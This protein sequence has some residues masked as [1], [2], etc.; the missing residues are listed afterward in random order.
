M[1][2]TMDGFAVYEFR[3]VETGTFLYRTTALE[4]EIVVANENLRQRESTFRFFPVGDFRIPSLHG[5]AAQN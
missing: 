1:S 5:E 3:H 2:S 4:E